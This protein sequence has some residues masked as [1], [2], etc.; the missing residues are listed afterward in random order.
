VEHT[1]SPDAASV[2]TFYLEMRAPAQLRPAHRQ[3]ALD[4][5]ECEIPQFEVNRFLY[6]FVGAAWEWT[7]KLCWR[8]EQ[9]RAWAEDPKLRTWIAYHRGSPAGYFELQKQAGDEVEIAYFGLAPAFI[10]RGFGGDLL[11]RGIANAWDW[12]AT[13]VWVHTCSLDHPAA[14]ANYQ[15][16]GM[17]LYRQEIHER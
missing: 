2:T 1:V 9:W 14:L 10:G 3:D 11:S 8:D 17:R 13:R 12:D 6:R 16:R 7:D 15:A 4:V 5:R